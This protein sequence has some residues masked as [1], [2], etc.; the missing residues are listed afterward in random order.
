[1]NGQDWMSRNDKIFDKA[2]SNYSSAGLRAGEKSHFA[3][4]TK[5]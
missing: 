2:L 4:A 5:F 3:G 1:M